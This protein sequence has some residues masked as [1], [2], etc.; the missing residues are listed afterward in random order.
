MKPLKTPQEGGA[1]GADYKR[2]SNE[3]EAHALTWPVGDKVAAMISS[4][5]PAKMEKRGDD[6]DKSNMTLKDKI[7]FETKMKL[8][9]KNQDHLRQNM[10]N[11]YTMIAQNISQEVEAKLKCLDEY[12]KAKEDY[13]SLWMLDK[14][15][16]IMAD[17]NCH[18][19]PIMADISQTH[20]VYTLAQAR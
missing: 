12:T 7:R 18:E 8:F 11:L 15:D 20:N 14:I 1:G 6:P 17:Y 5:E 9:V 2:L 16:D 4:R 13:D 10:T 3:L 19:D